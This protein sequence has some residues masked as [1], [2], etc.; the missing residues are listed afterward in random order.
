MEYPEEF[1]IT[2]PFPA[3][4]KWPSEFSIN[5]PTLNNC[6]STLLLRVSYGLFANIRITC[7]LFSNNRDSIRDQDDNTWR[8]FSIPFYRTISFYI[9][10][11]NQPPGLPRTSKLKRLWHVSSL[12]LLLFV[13]I[14]DYLE[15]DFQNHPR[16]EQ[17][18]FLIKENP[19]PLGQIL[20]RKVI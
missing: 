16:M 10:W 19:P 4:T 14:R 20:R 7:N 12:F 9:F 13:D 11:Q 8:L 6:Y 5:F 18:L 3:V 15:L 2:I 17:F 1:P